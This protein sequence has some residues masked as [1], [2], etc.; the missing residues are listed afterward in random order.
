V[1][2][3]YLWLRYWGWLSVWSTQMLTN[4]QNCSLQI[5]YHPSSLSSWIF[6]TNLWVL[7]VHNWSGTEL[8]LNKYTAM[9]ITLLLLLLFCYVFIFVIVIFVLFSVSKLW[10]QTCKHKHICILWSFLKTSGCAMA[11][12][13]CCQPFIPESR[14]QS[15][16][17]S[18]AFCWGWS[19]YWDRF[20]SSTLVFP[21][22]IIFPM[23]Y[24]FH[25]STT[26]ATFLAV[27]SIVK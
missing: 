18:C 4:F 5:F 26:Y 11:Q 19:V 3:C 21:C 25:S 27:D 9:Y 7:R 14:V 22:S 20:I 6:G 15:L 24:T 23:L 12:M 1:I 8:D 2:S 16:A 13:V 17:S 10:W